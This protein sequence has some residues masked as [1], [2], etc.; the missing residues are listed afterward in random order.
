M[1]RSNR[2][3]RILDFSHFFIDLP[4]LPLQETLPQE[5]EIIHRPLFA[6]E[7]IWQATLDKMYKYCCQ[8]NTFALFLHAFSATAFGEKTINTF[9]S[10]NIAVRIIESPVEI[11]KF[12]RKQ[13]ETRFY[14]FV[15]G[16]E[17]IT[18]IIA[19][20]ILAAQNEHLTNLYFSI[21]LYQSSQFVP[22]IYRKQ[23]TPID[24]IFVPGSIVAPLGNEIYETM[25][26]ALSVPII[27]TG[28]EAPDILQSISM[29]LA[30]LEQKTHKIEIQYRS[31]IRPQGNPMSRQKIESVFGVADITL[32]D[33]ELIPNGRF[34]SKPDF[35]PYIIA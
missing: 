32:P 12:A 3:I 19:A 4:P 8:S 17:P 25:L 35:A 1:R 29:L 14:L 22:I 20:I 31:G 23:A 9:K 26:P 34:T 2:S 30:Q 24:G 16:F 21:E 28:T 6:P 10:N 7:S 27:I 5:I 15:S 13:K 11:I 33:L 18:A